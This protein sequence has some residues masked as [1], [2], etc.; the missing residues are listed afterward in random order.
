MAVGC[1]YFEFSARKEQSATGML[2]SFL[3]QIVGMESIPGSR[4]EKSY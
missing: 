1:F 2:G 3:K 4:T